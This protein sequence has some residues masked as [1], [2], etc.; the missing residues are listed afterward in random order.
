MNPVKKMTR[1]PR[2]F[3]T[4]IRVILGVCFW[5]YFALV[6]DILGDYLF[7]ARQ[8]HFLDHYQ[9]GK[10]GYDIIQVGH[11]SLAFSLSEI[12]Q[13]EVRKS[14]TKRLTTHLT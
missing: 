5:G 1:G 4:K 9:H 2:D 12:G 6:F 14:D 11:V 10:V 8:N 7:R 3:S 13:K